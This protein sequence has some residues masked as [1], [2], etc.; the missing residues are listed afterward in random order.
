MIYGGDLVCLF[1]I[2]DLMLLDYLEYSSSRPKVFCKKSALRNFAKFKG[3]HLSQSV[4]KIEP[5]AQVFFC[6]FGEISKNTFSYRTAPVAASL[7]TH[8]PILSVKMSNLFR[9]S[10]KTMKVKIDRPFI[11]TCTSYVNDISCAA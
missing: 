8:F 3:E 2:Y 9:F 11:L 5:L 7:S 1:L 4:I 6:E 10:W